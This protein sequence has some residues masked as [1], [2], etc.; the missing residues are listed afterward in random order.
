M[1]RSVEANEGCVESNISFCD[2]LAEEEGSAF[3][4]KM[5]FESIERFEERIDVGIVTGLGCR[6]SAFVDAI[7]DCIVDYM[8]VSTN[9]HRGAG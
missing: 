2:E 7:V 1:I 3:A 5:G 4:C 6:E 9:S 8:T